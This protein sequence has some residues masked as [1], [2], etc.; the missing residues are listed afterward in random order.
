L[1]SAS[2]AAVRFSITASSGLPS[3]KKKKT[4]SSALIAAVE[5]SSIQTKTAFD[6][7]MQQKLL[8]R[9]WNVAFI[10]K[11]MKSCDMSVRKSGMSEK[12]SATN[13]KRSDMK[14]GTS[15]MNDC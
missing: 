14:I 5:N 15:M 7:M 1:V 11:S 4:K 2:T 10:R 6:Q 3:E 12:R 8:L 13:V 9:K